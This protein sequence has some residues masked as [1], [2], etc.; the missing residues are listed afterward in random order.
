MKILITGISGY[1][2]K[3]LLPYLLQDKDINSIIGLDV[4]EPDFENKKLSFSKVDIRNPEII[5]Y[6][7][8]VD[9]VVHLAFI[10][11]EIK[12]KKLIY[13]INVNGTKN[14]LECVKKNNVKKLIVASSVSA[15]GSHPDNPKIITEDTP[16]RGNKNSYYS[17]TKVL[18]ERLLG[19]FEK[20]NKNVI[21]TRLRS[22]ILCGANCNNFFLD[23]LSAK[24]LIYPKGNT[25]GLPIVHQDDA[26]R[27]FY[28]A[29]KKDVS[30]AF[31][32]SSGNLSIQ[33]MSKILNIP[34]FGIPYF[35]LK[36]LTDFLFKIG[37]SSFS[38][39]W[40]ILGRYPIIISNEKAKNILGWS[41]KY[42]SIDAFKEMVNSKR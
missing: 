40:T 29:I 30:G 4:K 2:G 14:V 21:V 15:Y 42:N 6:F 11:S 20:E 22:S 18:M 12:D 41:P 17:Y 10:V 16:L 19:D 28:I 9:V 36:P 35:I 37:K 5:K 24:I 31:N 39:H 3:V 32:I 23:T 33:E 1:V 27:A 26:A 34:S 25:V 7:Q 8:D 38:S 13:D